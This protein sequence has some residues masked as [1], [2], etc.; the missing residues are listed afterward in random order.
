MVVTIVAGGQWGDEGKGK[1]VAYLALKDNPSAIARAGV[2]PNAGHTVLFQGKRYGLR[3]VPSGFVNPNCKLFIGAGVLVDP[4]VLLREI[5]ETGCGDRLGV[6]G[7]C[8]VIEPP[9][10]EED[11]REGGRIGT[12]GTGCGP[13]NVARVRRQAK[14]ASQV[15]ELQPYLAD[16][17]SELHEIMGEGGDI[18]VEGSQGFG[19]SLLYGTYPYVTSKDVTASSLAADVGLGPTEVDEVLLV[20]KAYPTRVGNGPFPT[21]MSQE[22]AE[23]AG[24]V[25]HGTVTGRRRRVGRFDFELARKACMIN[26]ATQLAITCLDRLFK[27]GPVRRYG[28]LPQPARK[29]IREVERELGVPVTLISTGPGI[30]DTIDL[31]CEKI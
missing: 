6:D 7:R 26:G 9:H 2:G 25:E 30:W 19:L 14:L 11:K 4:P 22:E 3:Q 20:F 17:P 18:L 23:K 12:T 8:A 15:Q 28:D 24:I 16:V 31:R 27:T 21:E 5:Q 29:F 13:A 1:I 10:I